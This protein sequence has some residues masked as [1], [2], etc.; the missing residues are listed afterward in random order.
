MK[1]QRFSASRRGILKVLGGAAVAPYLAAAGRAQTGGPEAG[2]TA[3][4]ALR[5]QPV[6]LAPSPETASIQ[7]WAFDDGSPSP[8]SRMAPGP[9]KASLRNGS[10]VPVAFEARGLDGAR[11]AEPLLAQ[12]P[13]TPGA[14]VGLDLPFRQP[15][16]FLLDGRLLTDG[17]SSLILARVLVAEGGETFG[18]DRDEVILIEDWKI[19]ADGKALAPGQDTSVASLYTVNR[20]PTHD[21]TLKPNERVRLRIVNGC[22]RLV[23]ALKIADHDVNVVAIDSKP[24]E[25]FL[26]RDGQIILAPGTR[27]DALLDGT[28][29]V[30]SS[31]TILL[32]DGAKPMP[33]G[34]VL[35]SGAPVR[36]SALASPAPPAPAASKIDLK[37][38]Q[39]VD[40]SLDPAQW[41]KANGFDTASKPV[42][43]TKKDRTVVL[44]ITNG[45]TSAATVHL[46][47]HH[48]RLLDKLDDGWKPFWLDTLIFQ[49]GQTQRVA[50][51]AEFAGNWLIESMTTAWSSP[52]LLR[53]YAVE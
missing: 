37:N 25:P 5:I 3:G 43:R 47:G 11:S 12:P 29:P 7:A 45:S 53:W 20:K 26:A 22:Q 8:V 44:S 32:H 14:E 23:I 30:G 31:S 15:G 38:A 13:V 40:L 16:T 19:G 39:R 1:N 51:N 24:A 2:K 34:R 27:V 41:M 18:A 9:V 17:Q 46:H 42:F 21:L 52:R 10:P 4:L 36:A 6:S 33:I 28:T 48:V 50:F 49:P 35:T